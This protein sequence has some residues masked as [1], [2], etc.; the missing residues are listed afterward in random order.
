[1]SE[2]SEALLRQAAAGDDSLLATL[3]AYYSP[4]RPATVD[5]MTQA[6]YLWERAYR[7]FLGEMRLQFL[8]WRT[9]PDETREHYLAEAEA[10]DAPPPAASPI[11]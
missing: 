6:E 10:F 5:E 11:A 7:V 8:L 3:R 2:R 4:P 1:M 9:L